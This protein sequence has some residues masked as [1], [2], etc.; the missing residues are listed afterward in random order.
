MTDDDAC[1]RDTDAGFTLIEVVVALGLFAIVAAAGAGLVTTVLDVER[2]T[3]GRLARLADVER[4][5][6]VV[7]RDL[8][9]VADAPLAGS[10]GGVAFARHRGGWDAGGVVATS[11]RFAG[12]RFERIAAGR[13]QR[14]LDGVTAVRWS[15]YSAPGGWAD[16]WPTDAAGGQWP[17]AVAVDV[18]LAGPPPAGRLRRVVDL[19]V[20]P[21]PPA[22]GSSTPEAAAPG[23]PAPE[24]AASGPAGSPMAGSPA[25]GLPTPHSPAPG[26][27]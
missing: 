16:H 23:S 24:P 26:S 8:T 14:L 3:A 17:A 15:Y 12:S 10:R 22:T 5:M 18:D 13:P 11:Y 21:L 9:E 4:A 20:R 6:A 19:P 25:P 7:A 1:S 2:H 27:P